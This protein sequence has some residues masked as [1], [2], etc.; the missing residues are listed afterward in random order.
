MRRP[1]DGSRGR[2]LRALAAL[3]SVLATG[4][5]ARAS[6]PHPVIIGLARE[7]ESRVCPDAS[8]V[9]AAARRLFPRVELVDPKGTD[10]ATIGVSIVVRPSPPGHVATLT[11]SGARFGERTLVDRDPDCGGLADAIAVALVLIVDPGAAEGVG[12]ASRTAAG[13]G[14]A[15]APERRE[16]PRPRQPSRADAVTLALRADAGALGSAGVLAN[17]AV[18]AFAGAD[19]ALS[20]G[21]GFRAR[22]LRMLAAPTRVNPGTI[23]VD[24]WAALLGPCWRF[25]RTPGFTIDP[26]LDLGVGRQTGEGRDFL[27]WS[28][29]ATRPFW[30]L[31]P[32]VT[33]TRSL[34]WGLYVALT[35][36]LSANLWRQKYLVD[37]RS[38]NEQPALG[39]S[40]GLGLG[41]E[42][43]VPP[44]GR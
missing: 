4:G 29:P 40:V 23:T 18:G 31:G 21:L 19:L 38:E 39:V 30:S 13:P 33:V 2:A 43:R 34:L 11:V 1:R 16:P 28:R 5:E 26:C 3:L 24:L 20:W 14:G 15:R 22:A 35:G 27:R 44:G 37:G 8:G 41:V 36:G 17:P 7:P 6:A 9:L 25:R 42:G 12:A 10:D 32:S